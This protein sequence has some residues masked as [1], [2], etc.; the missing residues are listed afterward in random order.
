MPRLASCQGWR[1]P[2]AGVVPRLASCQSDVSSIYTVTSSFEGTLLN[3]SSSNI[4][5]LIWDL[6][7]VPFS[8]SVGSSTGTFSGSTY[9]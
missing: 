6:E 9:Y 4:F 8:G 7:V 3:I 1:H 5:S 2:K